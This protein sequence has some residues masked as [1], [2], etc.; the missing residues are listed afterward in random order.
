MKKLLLLFAGMTLCVALSAQEV[1]EDK[2]PVYKFTTVLENAATPVKSQGRT[3]TCWCFASVSFLESEALKSGKGEIDLSEMFVVRHN[4]YDRVK[5][6]FLRRGKGNLGQGSI[7]HM[8]LNVMDKYGLVPQEAYEGNNT[9]S[10]VYDHSELSTYLRGLVDAALKI[11]ADKRS[12]K[13]YDIQDALF[14]TYMGP[15]PSSFTY[16]GKEYTPE[17][18]R[19][20]LGLKKSDYVEITSYTHHPFYET[21]PLEI[22]DNW[23]HASMYNL[24]LDEMMGVIDYALNHGYTVCWDG[25]V[26]EPGYVFANKISIIPADVTLKREQVAQTDTLIKEASISQED[27]QKMFETFA[28][29]DEHLEHITGITLDQN[30]TKYYHTKNSWGTGRNADGYHNMSESYVRAKTIS[31][32][33]NKNALSKDIRKKLNIK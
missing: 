21:F 5:D 30:G 1:K 15:L 4:Y 13:Y 26:D 19:D 29:Q 31:V 9:D 7:G 12:D 3:G 17:S 22:G 10:P 16:Q 28:T 25:D 20:Y 27:R 18:F 33:V 24:P 14:D 2:A 23:D 11:P 32:L 8:T 6:N